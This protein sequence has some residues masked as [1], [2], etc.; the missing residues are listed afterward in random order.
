[1]GPLCTAFALG[2]ASTEGSFELVRFRAP[3][4]PDPELKLILENAESIGVLSDTN[5]EAVQGFDMEKVMGRLTDATARGLENLPD[6]RIVTQDEIRWH[7][8]QERSDSASAPISDS[9]FSR[10]SVLQDSTQKI[11]RERMEIDALVYVSLKGFEAQ[12]TPMSPSPYG[13]MPSPGM[14]VSVDLELMLI[15]LST[16]QSWSQTGQRH[17][18]QPVQLQLFGGGDRTERQLLAALAQ[19]LRRFL[20]R[21]APPPTMQGRHFDL[22][23]D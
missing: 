17:N 7:F 22:S 13:I 4:Y 1:M 11:L 9:L 19:P 18:W 10:G 6:T 14:N 3:A 21:V 23:G 16:G 2:C 8:K 20:V 15:N 12:M 5:I